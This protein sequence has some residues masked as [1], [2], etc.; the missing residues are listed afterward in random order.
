MNMEKSMTCPD[1]FETIEPDVLVA[2]RGGDAAQVCDLAQTI[3][4]MCLFVKGRLNDMGPKVPN[5]LPGAK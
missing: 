3:F 2:V 4:S 1:R 5:F